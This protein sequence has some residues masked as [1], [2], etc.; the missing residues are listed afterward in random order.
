[1]FTLC[2]EPLQPERLK[3]LLAHPRAGACVAFEGWVRDHNDG[4][5]VDHLEYE[6]FEAMALA[7]GERILAET[8]QRF[9]VMEAAAAHRIGELRI[10]DLAIW[11]GVTAEH[12]QE[13][14]LACRW[15]MDQ[16]KTRLTVWKREH[17]AAPDLPPVWVGAGADSASP[18]EDPAARPHYARQVT[19]PELGAEGQRRLAAARVLVIG[20]GGLGCPALQYLAAAGVGAITICDGDRID[21]TNLHRQVLFTAA[22]IGR[23]KA[24]VAADRLRAMNPHIAARAI[25]AAAEA[26]TLSELLAGQDLALD[27][28]DAFESKYAI[29]DACW[30]AGVPLI[31]ASVYQF[32]GQVQAFHRDQPGGCFR[33][34][35]P[36]PPPAGCVGN[37]AEA[38]VLGVTPGLLGVYQAIEALKWLL[39][40][41]DRLGDATLLVDVLTG[42]NRR[43]ARRP[44]PDCPCR[45]GPLA[46][47][48]SP[49]LQPG[50][51]A[52]RLLARGRII[53]LREA[54][55]R[56]DDPDWI[57][58]LPHMPRARWAD[59]PTQ[60]PEGPLILACAHGPRSVYCLKQLR[61]THPQRQDLYAW[62]R[63]IQE[64]AP[65]RTFAP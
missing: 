42:A 24:E 31:Q 25:A 53:D 21:P 43:I 9:A 8:R 54:E 3:A 19:L 11:V 57:Q 37:C 4:R 22:D 61:R 10:G 28:T 1:M 60:F 36:E 29:H 59:I 34:L 12:R 62:T 45:V 26:D 41:P 6:A 2:R 46:V 50:D 18:S 40:W 5:P 55:E 38:G 16:I 15:A 30:N 47:E 33:C 20:A 14:F 39:D 35:W 32:E 7:E 23:N 65:L 13:A 27:C 64:L 58:A 63:P 56:Q 48:S 52:R 51:R 44:R 17:Y 49:L